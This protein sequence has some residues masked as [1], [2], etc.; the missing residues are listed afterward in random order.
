MNFLQ[1]FFHLTLD[2]HHDVKL[3]GLA[4]I[5]AEAACNVCHQRVLM[6]SQGS[7]FAVETP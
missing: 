4:G 7:W 1:R 3:G 5:S 6:D 2:W